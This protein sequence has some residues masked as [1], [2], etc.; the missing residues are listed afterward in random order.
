MF[1]GNTIKRHKIQIIGK[2]QGKIR[3][4]KIIKPNNINRSNLILGN[5]A[6]TATKN[7]H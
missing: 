1:A 5:D 2:I 7:K 3:Y 4:N 6:L